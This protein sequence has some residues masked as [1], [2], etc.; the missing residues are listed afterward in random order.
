MSTLDIALYAMLII[1]T[2][3]VLSALAPA[4]LWVRILPSAT[5]VA[6]DGPYPASIAPIIT[7]LLYVIPTVI[8]FVSRSWQKALLLATL[9]AWL[10][11]GIFLIAA[12]FKVGAFYM[13]AS[14]NVTANVS[15]LELFA[16]LGGIGWLARSIFRMS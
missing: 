4:Q 11:L 6:I 1:E 12:T 14:A 3:L 9:P 10:G 8:G 7:L 16:A 13:I 5:S 15:T 2:L